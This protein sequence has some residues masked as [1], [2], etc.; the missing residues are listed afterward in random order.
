ML[1]NPLFNWLL[2][3]GA[4]GTQLLALGLSSPPSLPPPVPVALGLFFFFRLVMRNF[5]ILRA[6]QRSTA[7][8]PTPTFCPFCPFPLPFWPLMQPGKNGHC[9]R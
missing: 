6:E 9:Q 2:L 1:I 7:S 4:F 5:G 3:L 8:R